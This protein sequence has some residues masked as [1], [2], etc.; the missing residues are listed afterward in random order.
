MCNVCGASEQTGQT[1]VDMPDWLE[2]PAQRTVQRAETISQQPY[3]AYSQPR[4]AG[5]NSD[6]ANA[7]Q[8][9]RQMQGAYQGN[10]NRGVNTAADLTSYQTGS[11]NPAL[12][13]TAQTTAATIS[14]TA[15]YGGA[16][17]NNVAQM[18]APTMSGV[19]ISQYMDPYTN[20]VYRN[21]ADEMRRQYDINDRRIRQQ[22]TGAS[23]FANDGNALLR[24][25]N[26]RNFQTQLGN[27]GNQMLSQAYGNA[28]QTATGDLNRI[29]QA[30]GANQN[31]LNTAAL[32]NTGYAQ[33]AGLANQ[34][35]L[36]NS[37]QNQALLQQQAAL[38]NMNALNQ[39]GLNNVGAIN[40]AQAQNQAAGLQG[41]NLR[42]NAA[43]NLADLAGAA[44][45][46][47]LTDINAMLSS[48]QLQQ[49][50]SQA[51]LDLAYS[52]FQRQQ[53]Y[54]YEQL[55]YL[56]QILRGQPA[57]QT[58]YSTQP[59][60]SLLGSLTGAAATGIGLYNLFS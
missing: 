23:S 60:G 41:A 24:A 3:Q 17:V 53:A 20:T 25:E 28:Q 12:A 29:L 2:Q 9:V 39:V 58:T 40:N 38:A 13:N 31:A 6:Q 46:Y 36:N 27:V 48:G 10:I 44:Q 21:T 37:S 56:T 7:Q 1:T 22:A 42:L 8:A 54:P 4:I 5:F 32:T 49:Q 34:Q 45:N 18:T 33:Q 35:A 15:T 16:Q 43:N 57:G 11:I 50:Q 59:G 47:N 52:D 14:P 19:N 30:G 26:E 55:N 51:G